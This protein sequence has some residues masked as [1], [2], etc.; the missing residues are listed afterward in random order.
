VDEIREAH[1]PNQPWGKVRKSDVRAADGS[2][3]SGSTNRA[4]VAYRDQLNPLGKLPGSVWVVP[5]EP[6]IVPA[7]L[8]ID[9]FAAFPTEWP[10]RIIQG[11]SP[12]GVCVECGEGRRPV[13]LAALPPLDLAWRERQGHERDGTNGLGPSSLGTPA[14]LRSRT[15]TGYACACPEPTAPT[16]P[17][18]VLDPFGGTGTTALVADVLGRHGI[19]VDMSADYC[20]LAR[21]RTTDPGQ[22]AK[23]ARVEKP[24]VEAVGQMGFDFDVETVP[25]QRMSGGLAMANAAGRNCLGCG[26][27]TQRP[28]GCEKCG[29]REMEGTA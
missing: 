4:G 16:T 17:G 11:W 3:S 2:G 27:R 19:S 6:L 10:R 18:I 25:S 8:G 7:E 13:S 24:P 23:A 12:A 20:R 9:H 21:W 28:S 15:I 1:S 26:Y 29:G 14:L 22:R 5:T